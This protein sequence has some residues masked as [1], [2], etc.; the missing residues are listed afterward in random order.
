TSVAKGS[1]SGVPLHQLLGRAAGEKMNK[2]ATI[3]NKSN[4]STA[5]MNET[6]ARIRA[7][8]SGRNPCRLEELR[9]RMHAEQAGKTPVLPWG[10]WRPS[11]QCASKIRSVLAAFETIGKLFAVVLALT[12]TCVLHGALPDAVPGRLLVK[13]RDGINESDLQQLFASHGAQQHEAIH[14]INVR[15]LNVPEAARDH[16]LDALQHNS[17]IEFA[18]FDT[19]VS[20]DLTPN[21]PYYVYNYQWHLNN[22]AAPA[23]WD[24]T[25]G[26]SS[27]IIAI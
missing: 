7:C 20:P 19:I 6:S 10:Q 27:V 9:A 5:S 8:Q 14:Q 17:N 1:F 18:E 25:T 26:S 15:I 2:R 4:H 3:M 11:S 13:P 21:D 12:L 22:I 24:V 16:V 23:A